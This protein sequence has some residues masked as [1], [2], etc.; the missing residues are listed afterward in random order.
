MLLWLFLLLDG[1]V[2]GGGGGGGSP[3]SASSIDILR[4]KRHR[5]ASK[6]G[7]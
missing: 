4:V 2:S 6:G 3:V 7:K 1:D 5:T